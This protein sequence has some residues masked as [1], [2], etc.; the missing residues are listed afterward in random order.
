MNAGIIFDDEQTEEISPLQ[1]AQ[2]RLEYVQER[3]QECPTA[4]LREE[5]NLLLEEIEHLSRQEV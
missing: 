4:E 1:A 3:I 5:Y 2:S